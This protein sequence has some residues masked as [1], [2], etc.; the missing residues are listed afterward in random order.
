MEEISR[1]LDHNER[2]LWHGKP[3][4][5]PFVL[6]SMVL[7]IVGIF[8]LLISVFAILAGNL[9]P[10]GFLLPHFWIGIALTFGGPIYSWLVYKYVHYA[11]TNKRVIIKSGLIGR[12]F[13]TV[14]Y[15]LTM[16]R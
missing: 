12:D 16:T 4:F 9:G 7:S 5:W 13:K 1:I 8:F 10:F 15:G 3:N 14:D 6:G 2:I 11:I